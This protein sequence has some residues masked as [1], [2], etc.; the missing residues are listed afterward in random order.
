V[1]DQGQS[2]DATRGGVDATNRQSVD[3]TTDGV[4]A[5]SGRWVVFVDATD[6]ETAHRLKRATTNRDVLALCEKVLSGKPIE[7]PAAK[8][9]PQC[10]ECDRRRGQR[11]AAQQR[12]RK[13]TGVVREAAE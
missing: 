7:R 3:A 11:T 9:H 12:W 4:D 6:I 5:T 13:R 2:V 1:S 10:A 8:G